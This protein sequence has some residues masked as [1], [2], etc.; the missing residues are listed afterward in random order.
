MGAPIDPLAD[1]LENHRAIIWLS[2]QYFLKM[3]DIAKTAHGGDA[4]QAIIFTAL[5]SAN[6]NQVRA[7][8][9]FNT[10][11]IPDEQR[12]PVTVARLSQIVGASPETVR[13]H[14][15]RM[16]QAGLCTRDGRKGVVV[17]SDVFIREAMLAAAERQCAAARIY[18][19]SLDPLVS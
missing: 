3:L 9:G 13:R 5:W 17:T 8:G 14:V 18:H 12:R 19:R 16:E 15:V 6:V 10:A 2:A 11:L 4:M 7:R 1:R